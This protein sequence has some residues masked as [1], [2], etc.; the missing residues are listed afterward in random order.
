MVVSDRTPGPRDIGTDGHPVGPRAFLQ[1]APSG[2]SRRVA[3]EMDK[4]PHP[5]PMVMP[6]RWKL[7]HAVRVVHRVFDALG[8]RMHPDKTYIGRVDKGFDWL[9]YRIQ[10]GGLSVA[11]KTVANFVSRMRL[12]YE[13]EPGAVSATSRL[14][15]YVRH[16]W[17]WVRGG[18]SRTPLDMAGLAVPLVKV[19]RPE[20]WRL[21]PAVGHPI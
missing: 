11:A 21:T 15:V 10:P 4:P 9:G 3:L 7:R 18:L 16:W 5:L 14:G 19:D 8:L 2:A 13:R 1:F 6:T 20:S 12:L 17:R